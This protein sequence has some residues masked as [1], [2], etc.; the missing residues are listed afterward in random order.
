MEPKQADDDLGRAAERACRRNER[1]EAGDDVLEDEV[2]GGLLDD[3]DDEEVALK[4]GE[5]GVVVRRQPGRRCTRRLMHGGSA[6]SRT[7]IRSGSFCAA[8]M[9]AKKAAAQK[10]VTTS[11]MRH[12]HE[13]TQRRVGLSA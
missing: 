2:A 5:G 11:Q 3:R 1:R 13:S 9:T 7:P 10:K 4:V 12:S 6:D 8:P